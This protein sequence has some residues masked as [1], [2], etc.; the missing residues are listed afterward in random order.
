MSFKWIL[1]A[2]ID[3]FYA[4]AK[5]ETHTL[6]RQTAIALEELRVSENSDFANVIPCV[7][8]EE[9]RRYEV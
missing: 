3:E 2:L 9:A 4:Y 8:V 1:Y 6:Q 5:C 7:W